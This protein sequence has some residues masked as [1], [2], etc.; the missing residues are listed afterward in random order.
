MFQYP[1][2]V[3]S[4]GTQVAVH[5]LMAV[6]VSVP[7]TGRI[8][9]ELESELEDVAEQVFQYP[10]R[11]ESHWNHRISQTPNPE[12]MGFQYPLRVESHWNV[13]AG[14]MRIK[15]NV[16]FQYPLR[17]ESHWNRVRMYLSY[18][19]YCVSVPSTGRISLELY[20]IAASHSG[21]YVSVPSTGRISLER[22]CKAV[23]AYCAMGFSTLYGSNLIGTL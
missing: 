14:S 3:E 16:K 12:F 15:Q 1:L 7:S 11:V 13:I 8:S 4:I 10:L 23:R 2:R 9:L 20:I 21:Y 17:V 5:L 19:S 6:A 22:E 18:A